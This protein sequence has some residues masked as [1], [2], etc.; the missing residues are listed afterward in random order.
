MA[1]T[2]R[3]VEPRTHLAHELFGENKTDL[4]DKPK[5]LVRSASPGGYRPASR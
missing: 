5:D 3:G 2:Y 1:E 4:R